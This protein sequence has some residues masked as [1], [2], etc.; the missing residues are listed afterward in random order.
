MNNETV[1]QSLK[2][3]LKTSSVS[4]PVDID[5]ATTNLQLAGQT[6]I[7]FYKVSNSFESI[8]LFKSRL[9]QSK[10]KNIVINEDIELHGINVWVINQ[11]DMLNAQREIADHIYPND[12][13]IKLV[14]I[15]GTNG[16]TT[17]SYLAMQ[18]AT[19]MNEKSISIGTIGVRSIEKTLEKDLLSTTPS[20]L[21][22]RKIINKYQ[23]EY[24]CIFL[25]VSSHALVQKR[26][27]D[28]ELTSCAWTSFSQDHLDYHKTIDEY[29]DAK[30][31]I[32]TNANNRPLVV[33]S[34][35][36]ELI[37]KLEARNISYKVVEPKF[38]NGLSVGFKAKYNQSNLYIAKALVEEAIGKTIEENLLVKIKLP[39][40]RFE[41]IPF[42]E[43]LIL[44]DYAHTPD[45]LENICKT[46]KSDFSDYELHVVFGCGG[47]R[48]RTKRPLM[49]QAVSKYAD[50]IILTSDNPRTENPM[51]IIEDTKKGIST[52][53]IIEEDRKK[54]ISLSLSNLN[55]KTVVLIAGKGHEDY[56][57]I[58]GE[59]I[60][61][62]DSEEVQKIIKDI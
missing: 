29:F 34:F 14:G 6:D 22:L 3:Y 21:E 39:D 25:E 58:N 11:N 61:F 41:P 32:I 10:C 23:K 7:C 24:K 46:I 36:K 1:T 48:D 56:Q 50:R 47:D 30:A 13:S 51:T 40:G 55:K 33:S 17:C 42:N 19:L 12:G 60:H 18:L 2:K 37:K 44:I 62:S 45:A 4:I 57:D 59:K 15:T 54:A 20:Y 31:S 49:G 5:G 38:L 35:E 53:C 9:S 28:L 27:F 16:K 43:N 8:D 52:D 26:L